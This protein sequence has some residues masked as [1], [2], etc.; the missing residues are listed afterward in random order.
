MSSRDQALRDDPILHASGI[1][2]P[3]PHL[4]V[5]FDIPKHGNK[6]LK[7]RCLCNINEFFMS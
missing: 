4:L 3:F 6:I 5:S 2:Q 1:L 7:L